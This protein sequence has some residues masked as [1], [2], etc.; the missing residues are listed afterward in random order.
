MAEE[1]ELL[2]LCPPGVG[3]PAGVVH[4]GKVARV[5]R[6]QE[7]LAVLDRGLLALLVVE[8]AVETGGG[9]EGVAATA[10][11][12][13][14]KRKD[15]SSFGSGFYFF[16]CSPGHLADV[17]GEVAKVLPPVLPAGGGEVVAAAP[18]RRRGGHA[19]VAPWSFER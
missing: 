5:G 18:R 3:G 10:A 17:H 15:Y 13:P 12:A 1:L 6:L 14:R 16:F 7:V 11:G 2:H 8:E 4:G 9:A 19:F